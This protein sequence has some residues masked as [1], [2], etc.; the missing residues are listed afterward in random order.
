M[1]DAIQGPLSRINTEFPEVYEKTRVPEHK[2]V[3]RWRVTQ[4][5]ASVN[6][7]TP[8]VARLLA[9]GRAPDAGQVSAED[10]LPP[11]LR[12]KSRRRVGANE[13]PSAA[14]REGT[15][16][17]LDPAASHLAVMQTPPSSARR[18]LGAKSSARVQQAATTTP[19]Y[20]PAAAVL[21]RKPGLMPP[22]QRSFRSAV[23]VGGADAQHSAREAQE[24]RTRKKSAVDRDTLVL[25][26]TLGDGQEAY[27]VPDPDLSDDTSSSDE[28]AKVEARVLASRAAM[29]RSDANLSSSRRALLN[30]A[31]YGTTRTVCAWS[32][33]SLTGCS[34]RCRAEE[35][36]VVGPKDTTVKPA[37]G[38]VA[39]RAAGI[40]EL[41]GTLKKG[42]GKRR[43]VR[44]RRQEARERLE[45]V[46]V[47]ACVCA[48]AY[49]CVRLRVCRRRLPVALDV[50]K[51]DGAVG[52]YDGVGRRK[53]LVASMTGERRTPSR[54]IASQVPRVTASVHPRVRCLVSTSLKTSSWQQ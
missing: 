7:L 15:G 46:C 32:C 53:T 36:K 13:S 17:E 9:A 18:L 28:D 22:R 16:T 11:L 49:V 41:S 2:R 26:T 43:N 52:G 23:T 25:T 54:L 31:R 39:L 5:S 51:I 3:L 50:D 38:M 21:G 1:L 47:C 12:S 30:A 8:E 29:L 35:A 42:S 10:L 40:Q 19:R 48:C 27:V 4:A 45:K 24:A 14:G 20:G 34:R 44:R 6:V 33:K 37:T